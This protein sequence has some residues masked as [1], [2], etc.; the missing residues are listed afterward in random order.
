MAIVEAELYL[1]S[2][3]DGKWYVEVNTTAEEV[4]ALCAYGR[5]MKCSLDVPEET[6]VNI[7]SEWYSE[8]AIQ[9]IRENYEYHEESINLD[10]V[11][12]NYQELKTEE[13]LIEVIGKKEYEL[14][15]SLDEEEKVEEL[16]YTYDIEMLNNGN[17]LVYY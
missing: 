15:S 1:Q 16:R 7:L 10:D 3:E 4:F 6:L 2:G 14:L 5:L 9:F 8:E 11:F 13:E 17:Y 12:A